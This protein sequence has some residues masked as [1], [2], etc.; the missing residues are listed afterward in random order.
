MSSD[1][2]NQQIEHTE[3]T[4]YDESDE[5]EELV[6]INLTNRLL[7]DFLVKSSKKETVLACETAEELVLTHSRINSVLNQSDPSF[8]CGHLEQAE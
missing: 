4:A 1:N 2:A 5:V 3:Y 7:V 8:E 6:D